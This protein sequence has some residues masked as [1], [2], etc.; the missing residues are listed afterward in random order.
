MNSPIH[1]F[2]GPTIPSADLPNNPEFRYHPPVRNGSLHKL[3]L[4]SEDRVVIIDGVYQHTAPIRHKEILS[5]LRTG[6]RIW[7][8]ASMGALRAAELQDFGMQGVGA[9]YEDYVSGRRTRDSD[10]AVLQAPAEDGHRALTLALASVEYAL[11]ELVSL[12]VMGPSCGDAILVI[13]ERAHFTERSFVFLRERASEIGHARC[14]RALS[15]MLRLGD[16]KSRDGQL[17]LQIL[18]ADTDPVVSRPQRAI[19]PLESSFEAEERFA[20]TPVA[21]VD[22]EPLSGRDLLTFVQ[23]T[24]V[25]AMSRHAA[26]VNVLAAATLG[27][28]AGSLPEEI[29]NAFG[30]PDLDSDGRDPNPPESVFCLTGMTAQQRLVRTFRI[31]PGRHTYLGFDLDVSD[32]GVEP[33]ARDCLRLLSPGRILAARRSGNPESIDRRVI[34]STLVQLWGCEHDRLEEAALDRGFA[35]IADLRRR[36][37]AFIPGLRGLM[38]ING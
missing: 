5:V 25:D 6:A 3:G 4:G 24:D 33:L 15:A 19:P 2:V 32:G 28:A 26:H 12:G 35:D 16:Q 36:A 29:L 27:L 34:D 17:A 10:V 21:F 30:F 23:L 8:A 9:I 37:A 31:A 7:G 11:R 13:A 14:I 22:S 1:V 20:Q 18:A 38:Q